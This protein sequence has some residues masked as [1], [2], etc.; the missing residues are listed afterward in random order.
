M[1]S[2]MGNPLPYLSGIRVGRLG[3][4]VHGQRL[5]HALVPGGRQL[6]LLQELLHLQK[7][8]HSKYNVDQF[9]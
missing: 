5:E 1:M 8:H 6:G 3:V 7:D 9:M 4:P 2:E